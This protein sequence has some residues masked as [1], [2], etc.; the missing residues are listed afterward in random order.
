MGAT[1]RDINGVAFFRRQSGR[2]P[3]AERG[4]SW[5][6]IDNHI[7]RGAAKAA[8]HFCFREG[9]SLK[10]KPSNC[11]PP[12]IK[13]NAV[14]RESID[15]TFGGEFIGTKGPREL[16]AF[17]DDRLSPDHKGAVDL[18]RVELHNAYLPFA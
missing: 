16:A 13:G 17:V 2:T 3:L 18:E 11:A 7:E 10:V 5:T 14:L 15:Q 4:R 12:G 8:D 6:Q 9:L 1:S